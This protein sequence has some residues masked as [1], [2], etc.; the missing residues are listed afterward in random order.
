MK[1]QQSDFKSAQLIQKELLKL[2]PNDPVIKEFSKFLPTE[3]EYQQD[4]EDE[5]EEN[6][7]EYYDEEVSDPEDKD[8]EEDPEESKVYEVK[9]KAK[10]ADSTAEESNMIVSTTERVECEE[11]SDDE[12]GGTFKT[13]EKAKAAF[14][15]EGE[16]DPEE[17]PEKAAAMEENKDGQKAEE[18]DEYYDSDYDEQGRYIWGKEGEE[19][20][21]YYEEDKEAYELGLST[22][23][24]TLNPTALPQDDRLVHDLNHAT[25]VAKPANKD[26]V[27]KYKMA[28]KKKKIY[29]ESKK[30]IDEEYEFIRKV[31]GREKSPEA[32]KTPSTKQG[33][34][35]HISAKKDKIMAGMPA[36]NKKLDEKKK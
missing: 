12:D 3:I 23:P 20:E 2:I 14:M 28:K 33:F 9:P 6:K 8:S 18:S 13:G 4:A 30:D 16:D 7:I 15:M 11:D 32:K 21:F 19:W 31:A 10:D 1:L 34:G 22:V 29:N 17:D 27:A 25:G 5:A 26:F 35:V 24:E 36:S